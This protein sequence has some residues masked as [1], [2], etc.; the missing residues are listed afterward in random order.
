MGK[1]ITKR[2][3]VF[4]VILVILNLIFIRQKLAVNVGLIAG[5]ICGLLRFNFLSISLSEVL[6]TYD[7]GNARKRTLVSFVTSQVLI[8]V[9]LAAS[10]KMNLWLFAGIVEGI[11]IIPVFIVIN[12]ITE[13]LRV[14]HNHFE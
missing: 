12:G 1:F 11:L 5:T 6:G 4:S 13:Y 7:S 2:V 8:V 10:I 9:L 14:T 3:I